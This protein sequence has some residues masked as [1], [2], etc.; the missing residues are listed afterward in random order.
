M[1]DTKK[2]KTSIIGRVFSMEFLL[3]LVGLLWLGSGIVTGEPTQLFWGVTIAGGAVVLYFVRKKDWAKHWDEQERMKAAYD[4]I[5][6][7]EQD[8]GGKQ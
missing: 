6:K 8:N 3:L 4:E 2:Q 5:R 1:S 7:R